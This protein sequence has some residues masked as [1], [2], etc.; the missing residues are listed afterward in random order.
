MKYQ[1]YIL[2]YKGAAFLENW[3]KLENY[4]NC[5]IYIIDNGPQIW[6]TLKDRVIYSVNKNIGCAGGWNLICD[7]A[8]NYHN[9]DKIIIGSDDALFSEEIAEALYKATD[10]KSLPGTYDNGFHFAM[11]GISKKLRE[12]VGRFEE[13]FINCTCEDFD[14]IY[15][16][17]N[18]DII[19]FPNLG[20]SHKY[21][22]N[23][24]SSTIGNIQI[25]KNINLL[26]K[27]W[28][29]GVSCYTQLYPT[30]D[31]KGLYTQEYNGK[32]FPKYIPELIELY[33]EILEQDMFP[34]Q[35]QF[36]R[37]LNDKKNISHN[38]HV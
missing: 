35:I 15:R 5:D 14:Y 19:N 28:N 31:R 9:Q 8:F 3:L 33:P 32:E 22:H 25:Q 24:V 7:I 10:D 34:S 1:I 4:P 23:L 30:W 13:N 37:F 17:L 2:S 27:K 38:S 36:N 29:I 18:L 26:I 21:N 16:C 20:V 6:T 11:F 12:K